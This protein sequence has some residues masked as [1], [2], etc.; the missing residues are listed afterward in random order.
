MTS[1][2]KL[3]RSLLK[4]LEKIE[5]EAESEVKDEQEKSSDA[6][7]SQE[8]A[9]AFNKLAI[10]NEK[11]IGKVEQLQ[12]ELNAVK[13]QNETIW[14]QLQNNEKPKTHTTSTKLSKLR[15]IYNNI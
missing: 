1:T 3:E 4:T 14:K 11:L 2:K 9:S 13:S 8:M 6:E 5:S 15:D 7:Q 12:T 10:I